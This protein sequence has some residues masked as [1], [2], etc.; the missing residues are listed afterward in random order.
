MNISRSEIIRI[1]E[2]EQWRRKCEKA[3]G[4]LIEFTKLN[5][6]SYKAGDSHRIVAYYLE[7]FWRGEINLILSMPPR[8]GKSEL[9][10]RNLPA[11]GFGL[12]PEYEMIACSY[13]D[14]LASRMNRDVQR[15]IENGIYKDIFPNTRI[16]DL[17][18]RDTPIYDN[19]GKLIPITGNYLKNSSMFEIVGHG[20]VYRSAGV[21]GGITGMGFDRGMIDDPFKDAAQ[22]KS[23]T[24]R[25]AVW[26]WFGS[27]FYTRKAP[28]A[29]ICLIMTRWHEDDLAGKIIESMKDEGSDQY[30][31]LNL[32]AICDSEN[33]VDAEVLEGLKIN[34]RK[35]GEPLDVN[36]FNLDTLNKIRLTIGEKANT[37]LYQGKPS[38]DEGELF[39]WQNLRII[40]VAPTNIVKKIRY[41][42]KAGT[43]DGHGA[44][45]AGSLVGITSDNWVVILDIIS[46][47]WAAPERERIIKQTAIMDGKDVTVW[48]EQEPGSGGKESAESTVKNLQGFVCKVDKVSGD[49]V[50][51]AEPT[52][53][54]MEVMNVYAVDGEYL[55][56]DEGLLKQL[57]TFPNGK[58]KDKIDAT[59]GAYNKLTDTVD[60]GGFA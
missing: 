60:S 39:K 35:I 2:R 11:W 36:R 19:E 17:K 48:I 22:A 59:G 54:Q 38:P 8:H 26:E 27:V 43:Q 56:G 50:T 34:P 6:P 40:P 14:D 21:G 9:A 33:E 4:S 18:S 42:D 20:G 57:Q 15:V 44:Q 52:A 13:G 55:R 10:S 30:T 3:K 31:V 53:V 23:T 45:T 58:L 25:N 49:K 29:K 37:S 24:V 46:G 16:Q 5:N 51:R 1:A 41:W 28:N 32:P 12:N 7:K 47:R